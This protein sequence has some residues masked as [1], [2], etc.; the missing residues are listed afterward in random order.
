MFDYQAA[1]DWN[2]RRRRPDEGSPAAFWA[3]RFTEDHVEYLGIESAEG[4]ANGQVRLSGHLRRDRPGA[5]DGTSQLARFEQ[6]WARTVSGTQV[7]SFTVGPW[8]TQPN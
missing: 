6:I 2:G 1:I 4:L 7:T 3:A 8:E 5:N